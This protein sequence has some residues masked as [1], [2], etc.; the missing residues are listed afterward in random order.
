MSTIIE[1]TERDKYGRTVRHLSSSDQPWNTLVVIVRMPKVYIEKYGKNQAYLVNDWQHPT[2]IDGKYQN[3]PEG[4][5]TR[6]ATLAQARAVA[7][8]KIA[9]PHPLN[10]RDYAKEARKGVTA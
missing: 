4:K 5:L 6:V 8:H 9:H 10:A 7:A 3:E 2:I 1:R